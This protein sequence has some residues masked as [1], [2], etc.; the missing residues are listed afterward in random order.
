MGRGEW[1]GLR[2]TIALVLARAAT[3]WFWHVQIENLGDGEQR[4][5]LTYAQDLGLAHYGAV[6]LNEF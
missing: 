5:D 1:N 2:Y 4:V 3:A 6:R